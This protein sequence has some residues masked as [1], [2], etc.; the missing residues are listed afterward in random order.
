MSKPS[1]KPA[2]RPKATRKRNA[3]HAEQRT[4]QRALGLEGGRG[5]ELVLRGQ[6]RKFFSE[7]MALCEKHQVVL[8]TARLD[9][10]HADVTKIAHYRCG[11]DGSYMDVSRLPAHELSWPCKLLVAAGAVKPQRGRKGP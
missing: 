5:Q 11:G 3:L 8:H 4:M 10:L 1:P 7:L 2:S 6:H 9:I